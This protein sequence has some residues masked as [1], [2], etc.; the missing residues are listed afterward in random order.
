MALPFHPRFEDLPKILPVFPLTGALLLPHGK[1]PL[2]IF[3][4]R[5]LALVQDSLG[6]DRI[7][8]MIQP[9]SPGSGP[10]DPPIFDIGCAGRISAFQE[11]EDGRLTITLTGVC[12][13]RVA[14]EVEGA[15]GYRR[16]SADWDAFRG[17]LDED[18]A[19]DIDRTRLFAV[20]KPFLKLHGMELNWKAI[21][22]ASDLA[23]SVSLAM[24]CPLEP[25]EKQA[26]LESE[27]PGQRAEMLIALMEMS[28]AGRHGGKGLLRQ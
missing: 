3:E 6:W 10:H 20:L 24:A 21:E 17:D 8:G 1:L 27:T 9:A 23:L 18:P 19:I 7:F 26:L 14:E 28:L 13:F 16:V 5:Y 4:P 11:T 12:R 2:N 22:A 15:R 25:S